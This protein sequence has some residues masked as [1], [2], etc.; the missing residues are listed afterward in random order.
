MDLQDGSGNHGINGAE[1]GLLDDL[2]LVLAGGD[3]QHLAGGHHGTDT[4]GVGGGGHFDVAG[5]ALAE[6]ELEAAK[7]Q[8]MGAIDEYMNEIANNK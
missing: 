4:H 3:Q 2:G 8:L 6:S 7:L 5:A 1:E